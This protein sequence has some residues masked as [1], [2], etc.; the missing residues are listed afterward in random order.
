MERLKRFR[1]SGSVKKMKRALPL[2]KELRQRLIRIERKLD[3]V[4]PDAETR[5]R[6]PNRIEEADVIRLVKYDKNTKKNAD[7]ALQDKI[8][9]FPNFDPVDFSAGYDWQVDRTAK[10]GDSYQ[11][12]IQALRIVSALLLEY[13]KSKEIAY[14]KKARTLIESW[15]DFNDTK[16]ENRMIWYD[17]PAANRAQNIIHF[18]FL[19]QDKFSLDLPRY[20]NVLVEHAE[21]MSDASEYR[22]NNHGLM[23]DRALMIIGRILGRED[24]FNIG[25]YRA[26]DTFWFSFS[27]KAVHLENSPEYHNMVRN[28][29][30]AMEEYLNGQDKSF[31]S[32]LVSYLEEA[33]DYLD[34]L[35]RPDRRL[36]AIGDSGNS[37][38]TQ[39]KKYMNFTDYESGMTILQYKEPRPL[40]LSFIAGFSTNTHKHRDDL[41][42]TLQYDMEDILVDPGKF[43]YSRN[44][45]RSYM[46]SPQAHSTIFLEKEKYNKSHDNRF[47]RLVETTQFFKN[48]SYVL[49]RGE[50]RAFKTSTL[51]RIVVMLK[52][53]PIVLLLDKAYSDE[54]A[55][56]NFNLDQ[57]VRV[58]AQDAAGA[59]VTL[60]S[61]RK[62]NFR[63]MKRTEGSVEVRPSLKRPVSSV[64]TIGF[65]KAAETQQLR[66]KNTAAG[67]DEFTFET[68]IS[69]DEQVSI[70]DYE[71]EGPLLRMRINGETISIIV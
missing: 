60:P 40:Y 61:G 26:I 65:G 24:L 14:L 63:Q 2:N 18:L 52:D 44:P 64:N 36:P 30:L 3:E 49:V 1:H 5:H 4:G 17:H 50:N 9:P 21:F 13:E 35:A 70:E 27:A 46:Q 8:V 19:A 25:Y 34:I 32:T 45:I 41:S 10:Y 68:I 69:M 12:Y 33:Q 16:P 71:W 31:G 22:P 54:I 7:M 48:E 38:G 20:H 58:E 23:M 29:Y 37:V 59:T 15:M 51:E 55:Y 62:V 66:F 11:L 43:N 39:N 6:L 53:H 57:K 56:Q 42:I 67:L 47:T 28:M